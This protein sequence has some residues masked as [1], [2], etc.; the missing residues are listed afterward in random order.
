MVSRRN[1]TVLDLFQPAEVTVGFYLT[2]ISNYRLS[3]CFPY[4]GFHYESFL[5]IYSVVLFSSENNLLGTSLQYPACFASWTQVL[6]F[7]AAIAA[8]GSFYKLDQESSKVSSRHI[9][10]LCPSLP[11]WLLFTA[12]ASSNLISVT[13]LQNKD[14]LNRG[15][16]QDWPSVTINMTSI[17]LASLSGRND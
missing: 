4:V 2:W 13:E 16:T 12:S 15:T 5:N 7:C 14:L 8:C 10:Q 11:K 1:Q 6:G 3:N 17:T 9:S